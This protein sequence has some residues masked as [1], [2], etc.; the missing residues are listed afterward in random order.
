MSKQS[1]R[2]AACVATAVA[3]AMGLVGCA[4]HHAEPSSATPA[5]QQT[6]SAPQVF[7][8]RTYACG[9][10]I[11]PPLE[12]STSADP[13]QLSVTGTRFPGDRVIA[14]FKISSGDAK[15]VLTYPVSPTPPTILLMRAG[16]VVGRHE[17]P[18]S[19][20]V[21]GGPAEMRPI[22]RHTYVSSLTVD[23][24]CA[25]TT[26]TQIK[27]N[28]TRYRV[29]IVMSRQPTSGPQTAPPATYLTDPLTTATVRLTR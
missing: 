3:S 21:E 8:H 29:E 26:W 4:S 9:G 17:A 10:T 24:L 6:T 20:T 22:G 7:Q 14:D 27:A 23:Q 11:A 25:G 5:P 15:I 1:R 18:A 2:A 13:V 19:G 12:P 28:P 16:H